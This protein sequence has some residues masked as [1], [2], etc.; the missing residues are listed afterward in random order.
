MNLRCHDERGVSRYCVG[1]G[2]DQG[3]RNSGQIE[4]V[5]EAERELGQVG[6]SI[7]GKSEGVVGS[8]AVWTAVIRRSCL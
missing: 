3:E 5:I 1:E 2:S 4:T 6:T 8:R 7:L